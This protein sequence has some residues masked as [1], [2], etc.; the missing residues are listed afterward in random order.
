MC[1]QGAVCCKQNLWER[2]CP[3]Q[4]FTKSLPCFDAGGQECLNW[5]IYLH[6]TLKTVK[7]KYVPGSIL[8]SRTMHDAG[9]VKMTRLSHNL[10]SSIERQKDFWQNLVQASLQDLSRRFGFDGGSAVPTL[11][12]CCQKFDGRGKDL[13]RTGYLFTSSMERRKKTQTTY[14]SVGIFS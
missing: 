6:S 13:S 11:K 10:S 5:A 8:I 14:T 9:D 7:T 12:K 3:Q 2:F 1:E 4:N